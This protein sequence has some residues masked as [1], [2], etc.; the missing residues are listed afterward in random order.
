MPII[1]VAQEEYLHGIPF[2]DLDSAKGALVVFG[3]GIAPSSDAM[4]H[5]LAA[6]GYGYYV[7]PGRNLQGFIGAVF[8][9]IDN[10]LML[11]PSY[12]R[13]FVDEDGFG[14]FLRTSVQVDR[15]AA[16]EYV[17]SLYATYG[18]IGK[19]VEDG[20][21]SAIGIPQSLR[22]SRINVVHSPAWY[23]KFEIDFDPI[24][25]RLASV[26][27]DLMSGVAIAEAIAASVRKRSVSVHA[28]RC[29][30]AEQSGKNLGVSVAMDTATVATCIRS[31]VVADGSIVRG[32]L[33]PECANE[34]RRRFPTVH[35]TVNG[36]PAAGEAAW[37]E[38]PIIDQKVQSDV[39]QL[40]ARIASS[41]NS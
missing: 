35:I 9:E 6:N 14:P 18:G 38:L 13:T 40:T 2:P 10:R 22:W 27:F 26:G 33:R 28:G 3:E 19:K 20:L 37:Q 12:T 23:G 8:A 34:A 4:R 5:H 16:K 32:Q 41:F 1:T 29:V 36:E 11:S 24:A 39:R 15:T 30:V 21:A 17:L 7:H 31:T 25:Q